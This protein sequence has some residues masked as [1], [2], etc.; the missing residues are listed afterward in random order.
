MEIRSRVFIGASISSLG[1]ALFSWAGPA[2]ASQRYLCTSVPAACEYAGPDA[3]VLRAEVCWNGSVAKLKGS[4]TCA[5]GSRPYWV[6]HGSVDPLTGAVQA[7]ISLADACS[8][9]WCTTLAAGVP[10]PADG[11]EVCCQPEPITGTCTLD[12]VDCSGEI[13]WCEGYESNNDGTI[14]CM[15]SD[16]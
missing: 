5:S 14:E 8:L 7:Y 15:H 9:G 13:L 11:G 1:L 12:V 3:P 16:E 4:A 2:E 6:E 10:L